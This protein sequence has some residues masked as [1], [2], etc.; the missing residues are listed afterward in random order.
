MLLREGREI[1]R[2]FNR[3]KVVASLFNASGNLAYLMGDVEIAR[4]HYQ[5]SLSIA[6]SIADQQGIDSA[7]Q[8]IAELLF[9]TGERDAAIVAARQALIRSRMVGNRETECFIASNLAAYLLLTDELAEGTEL[10][11]HA[12]KEAPSFG[13]HGLATWA[14]QHLAFAAT[15]RGDTEHAARLQGFVD[16]FYAAQQA[17]RQPTEQATSELT[18]AALTSALA[19]KD[20]DRLMQQGSMMTLDRIRELA[21]SK[22][23]L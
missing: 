17:T 21:L 10:A 16:A 7:S 13:E 6:R 20:R 14:V 1:A 2:P 9:A 19:D 18:L 3:T 23:S 22:L 5:K 8:N 11:A 4:D 15:K 12:L